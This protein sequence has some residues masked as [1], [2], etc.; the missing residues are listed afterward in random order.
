MAKLTK[1]YDIGKSLTKNL[2]YLRLNEEC[3]ILFR[4][5]FFIFYRYYVKAMKIV[6]DEK[7]PYIT[8]AL[9]AMGHDVVALP[10]VAIANVHLRD[11]DALFVRTR[12]HCNAALLDGSNVRFIGT[13]TIGYDHIDAAYCAQ[14]NIAWTNA[15]G[16]NADA[17]LQYVQAVIYTWAAERSCSL[18]GLTLGVVGVGE[19]GGRV[20]R[21]AS[22]AGLRL[23]LN[24]PLREGS[25]EPGFVSL[26]T[27]AADSDIIT[28][29]PTLN[30]DGAYPSYHLADEAFFA[31]MKRCCLLI[32]ASR[33]P[34]VDNAALL[35]AMGRSAA[36][37]V[38]LDVWEGEPDINIPLLNK[39]Y[40]ATPH[41]AGYS[42]EGK[43]NATNI[44]LRRFAQ[45]FGCEQA[46][47]LLTLPAP[48]PSRVVAPSFAAACL[49]IYNP[50]A[51]SLALKT[52][53][54]N[55]EDLRNNYNLRREPSAF[56]IK[57]VP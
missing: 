36:L 5:W 10:G 54:Q 34:V 6:I 15:A 33:G 31:Q 37:D 19:I 3:G 26:A 24:D 32:N 47:P 45:Y 44:V 13:A 42:A 53:P 39:V 40:I 28:F 7:I 35:Q 50:H 49:K 11:A 8:D 23:L 4:V 30:K 27:I 56:E 17:V 52:A 29:H 9:L 18:Q 43:L 51:D 14:N 25:G 2:V 48:C 55:F 16:C 21:W 57:I 1:V 20:A 22:S 38:V 46:L 12:T 41:I